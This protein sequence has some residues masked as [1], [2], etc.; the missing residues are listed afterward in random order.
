MTRSLLPLLMVGSALG[1]TGCKNYETARSKRGSE[2]PDAPQYTIEEQERRARARY[3]MHS[4]D[5]RVGPRTETAVPDPVSI[6]TG[7]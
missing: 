2:R 7:R 1:L 4:D 3:G 6:G 5:F